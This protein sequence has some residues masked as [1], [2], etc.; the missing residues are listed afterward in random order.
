MTKF[1]PP[2]GHRLE[3]ID[4]FGGLIYPS[5]EGMNRNF[6][7]D[8]FPGRDILFFSSGTASLYSLFKA[9]KSAHTKDEII[10]PGYSCPTIAAAIIRAGL[11]PVLCDQNIHDFGLEPEDLKSKITLNTLAI[12]QVELFG[13]LP[14]NQHI[15]DISAK[16]G[17]FLIGDIAQSLGNYLEDKNLIDQRQY[18]SLVM[19]FGRGKPLNLLHGGGIISKK[20]LG[21][22]YDSTSKNLKIIQQIKAFLNIFLFKIFFN[23]Y[24]YNIPRSLPFLH[25]GETVFSLNFDTSGMSSYVKRL[26]G[27]VIKKFNDIHNAQQLNLIKYRKIL[28]PYK[29]LFIDVNLNNDSNFIRFPILFKSQ[30][31][32]N[33]ALEKLNSSGVGATGL[34]PYSLDL[35]PGLENY[36]LQ[37]CEKSFFISGRILTLP[38]HENVKNSDFQK[39]DQI[40]ASIFNTFNH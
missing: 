37:K 25:L 10:I 40:F 9:L 36:N 21:I 23:P 28:E 15:Y 38:V 16:S 13:L 8:Y 11:R 14:D 31:V 35:Q 32:R 2:A 1:T 17:C 19:S 24:L 34:Y 29:S 3:W 12:V 18:D 5:F 20:S 6:L 26:A 22:V 33:M 7:S 39:I 30:K 27:R 4:I